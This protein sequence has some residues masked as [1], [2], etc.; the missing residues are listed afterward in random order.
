LEH[1]GAL[2]DHATWSRT[3]FTE[4]R[5]RTPRRCP[6]PADPAHPPERERINGTSLDLENSACVGCSTCDDDPD[7]PGRLDEITYLLERCHDGGKWKYRQPNLLPI[8]SR[9]EQ[10]EP[11]PSLTR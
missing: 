6:D 8:G 1:K 5:Q 4:R 7:A 3:H 2:V 9:Q 10:E 11:M